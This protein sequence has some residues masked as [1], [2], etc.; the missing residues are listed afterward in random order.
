MFK[1]KV[2]KSL[3][4]GLLGMIAGGIADA[5][6]DKQL[7]DAVDERIDERFAELKKEEEGS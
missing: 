1:M 2:S 5:I 6:H 7:M 3:I 4:L